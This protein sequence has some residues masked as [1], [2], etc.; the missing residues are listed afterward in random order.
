MKTAVR[1]VCPL[2]LSLVAV[3]AGAQ[4]LAPGLWETTMT[5]TS[6]D[7]KAD[8][9]MARM[10]SEMSKMPPEQRKMIE[11]MMAKRGVATGGAPGS[12]R[13]CLTPEQAAQQEL[14]QDKDAHCKRDMMQRTGNT[15]RFKFH[16]EGTPPSSGE[17]EWIFDS[18]K[19]YHGKM[20]MERGASR[21]S[22]QPRKMEMQQNGRWVAADCGSVKPRVTPGK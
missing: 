8:A 7:G 2:L 4:K 3:S 9:A 18:D 13:F 14:P 10:Q 15:L 17:G 22:E 12:I 6:D 11:D 21:A 20:V 16:C 19:A 5:M 1:L